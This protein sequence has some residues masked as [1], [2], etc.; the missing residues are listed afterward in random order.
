MFIFDIFF[1]S[2]NYTQRK[3]W[4]GAIDIIFFETGK[5]FWTNVSQMQEKKQKA[6]H[7]IVTMLPKNFLL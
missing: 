6:N 2:L 5:N 7:Y 3:M 4:T 1:L